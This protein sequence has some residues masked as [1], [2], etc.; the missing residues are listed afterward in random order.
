M[1]ISQLCKE[2]D[3]TAPWFAAACSKLREGFRYHRK[4]WEWCY[5]YQALR[6]RG[7]LM[8]FKRGLGFGVGKEPLAAAFASFGC[9]IVATDMDVEAAKAQGWVDTNQ[10]AVALSDLNDRGLCD[11]DQFNHLVTYE[12][13]D[14]NRISDRYIGQFDF[15]W[16]SCCFEHLGSIEHGKQ[17]IVNQMNCLRPGGVAVH[18]TEFNLSS[19]EQTLETDVLVLYRLRDIDWMVQTLKA[20]GYKVDIDYTV[21]T[22]PIESYV[23]VPPFK[24]NPHLRLM[25]DRYVSTSVGLIIEKPK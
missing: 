13:A 8:P 9:E 19:N 3:F 25:L 11:P 17:F 15:T 22:G 7:A 5:I 1:L 18:T 16:S 6:E 20:Y 10:H 12:T 24:L 23:D 14:M 4:L 2:A 21:G